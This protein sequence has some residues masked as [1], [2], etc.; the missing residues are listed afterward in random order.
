MAQPPDNTGG[1]GLQFPLKFFLDKTFVVE[2]MCT[3]T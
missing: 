1:L 2:L 3:K